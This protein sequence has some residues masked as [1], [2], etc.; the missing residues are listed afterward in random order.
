MTTLI[1]NYNRFTFGWYILDIPYLKNL[2][3][4]SLSG[5]NMHHGEFLTPFDS[6]CIDTGYVPCDE[7]SRNFGKKSV[8]QN[9]V[10]KV[11]IRTSCLDQYIGQLRSTKRYTVYICALPSIEHLDVSNS[12]LR[13][14]QTLNEAVFDARSLKTFNANNNMIETIVGSYIIRDLGRSRFF[15]QCACNNRCQIL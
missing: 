12:L 6:D 3:N 10:K 7:P 1:A 4:L 13:S 2:K 14:A 9:P 11:H 5:M 15:W 8:F